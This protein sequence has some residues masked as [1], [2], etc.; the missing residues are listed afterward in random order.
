LIVAQ[1]LR[2]GLIPDIES[3]ASEQLGFGL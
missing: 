3:V 1:S 2:A